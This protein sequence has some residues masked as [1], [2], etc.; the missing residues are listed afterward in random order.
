VS[1]FRIYY[2]RL[3]DYTITASGSSATGYPTA[4]LKTYLARDIWKSNSTANAQTLAIDLGSAQAVDSIVLDSWNVA[5]MLDVDLEA[6]DDAGFTT[7]KV[8]LVN[9]LV[10]T[11]PFVNDTTRDIHE[12]NSVTKRYWRLLW[13]DA[14]G[15]APQIGQIFLCTR[16]Q[17]PFPYDFGF[18]RDIARFETVRK[19]ALD[20]TLRGSQATKGRRVWELKFALHTDAFAALF[21]TFQQ[22]V[23]GGL[24]PFFFVDIDGTKIRYMLHEADE[25]PIQGDAYNLNTIETLTM[26]EQLA[27]IS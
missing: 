22:T 5:S 12:F 1:D 16:L 18:K 23:R 9:N 10:T 11:S 13:N 25:Q 17:F 2:R 14:N 24:F 26:L 6:A 19:T 8:L 3:A 15:T 21:N 7:N 27:E 4:N 20:G